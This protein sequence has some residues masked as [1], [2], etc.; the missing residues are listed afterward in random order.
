MT[1]VRL[2]EV[3]PPA[4]PVVVGADGQSRM[5]GPV[6]ASTLEELVA[7]QLERTAHG[8]AALTLARFVDDATSAAEV[9]AASREMRMQLQL[10]RTVG[11]RLSPPLPVAPPAGDADS[12]VVGPERLTQMRE[13]SAY[14][15]V[16]ATRKRSR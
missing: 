7:E 14:G 2:H 6:E 9:S 12:S 13:R 8:T 10:A 4:R 1:K 3:A 16:P 15:T 5:L 11:N